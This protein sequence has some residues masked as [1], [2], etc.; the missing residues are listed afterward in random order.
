MSREEDLIKRGEEKEREKSGEYWC[1]GKSKRRKCKRTD[2]KE[3]DRR[4]E[5]KG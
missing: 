2:R 3:V 5:E 4:V 1:S